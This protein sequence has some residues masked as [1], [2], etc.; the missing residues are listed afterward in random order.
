MEEQNLS[1]IVEEE[2]PEGEAERAV[3]RAVIIY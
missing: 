1:R 3:E 2:T